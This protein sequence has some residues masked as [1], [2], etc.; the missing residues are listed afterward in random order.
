MNLRTLLLTPFLFLVACGGGDADAKA[1]GAANAK[2]G[3]ECESC[4]SCGGEVGATAAAKGITLTDKT[5]ISAILADPARFE[6]KR[7][8]VSGAAVGVCES[9]GCWV[10]LKSDG[11]ASKKIR[12]KVQDGEIVFPMTCKGNEVTVEGVVEKVQNGWWIRGLGA[13]FNS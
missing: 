11:D 5:A 4:E 8:L 2:A 10:D 1:G 9:R 12:V 3:H 13:K 6:G 7:V